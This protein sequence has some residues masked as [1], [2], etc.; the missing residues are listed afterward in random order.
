MPADLATSLAMAASELL[1]NAVEH[2]A[3]DRIVVSLEREPRTLVMAVRDDGHGLSDDF[4]PAVTGLGL[5]IVQSLVTGDLQ[6]TCDVSGSSIG[7]VVVI[8][9]PSDEPG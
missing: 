3:A 4:D 1:H 5:S 6:G 2:A 9:V 8:R 7:T